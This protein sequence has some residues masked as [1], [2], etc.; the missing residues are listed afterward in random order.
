MNKKKAK[1]AAK[2]AAGSLFAAS[3]GFF[4]FSNLL[5]N[6]MFT[7]KAMAKSNDSFTLEP[8][9]KERYLKDPTLLRDDRTWYACMDHED[10]IIV[11]Q[12]GDSLFADVL[13]PKTPSHVWCIC[14]H[15]WT[16]CPQNMAIP[17]RHY[18]EK[19]YNVLLPHMRAHGKSVHKNVGM[20]WF[21]RLDMLDWIDHIL[22][23]DPE[24]EIFMIGVSMGAATVM[25]TGGEELPE[26]V[27]CLIA[28]CG[29]SSVWDEITYEIKHRLH[30]PVHPLGDYARLVGRLRAGYDMK[31][32]SCVEQLKKC[33]TP[34]LFI[35]GELDDFV[36]YAMLEKVYNAA[37]GEKE[38]LSVPDAP[39]AVSWEIHPELYWPKADN[40][41]AKYI[42]ETPIH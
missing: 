41:L 42:K 12:R 22:T 38:I 34:I 17:A 26:N 40:F 15:G 16:S 30:L 13:R 27:K 6:Q 8:A 24:A 32:A 3:A 28:D 35:H 37:A 25:M 39:H 10:F 18:Y 29:Y 33:K 1:K 31:K 21:D 23:I 2:I 9:E 19:G 7:S 11:S 4:A 36:P 20:G 14:L 5:Y